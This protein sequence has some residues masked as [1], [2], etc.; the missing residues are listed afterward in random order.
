LAD[1]SRINLACPL[2]TTHANSQAIN[3]HT[4]ELAGRQLM[5]RVAVVLCVTVPVAVV[6]AGVCTVAVSTT[7][8]PK[9]DGFRLEAILVAVEA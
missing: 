3:V 6:P 9:T 4:T 2:N 7:D 5:V 8:C 1:G